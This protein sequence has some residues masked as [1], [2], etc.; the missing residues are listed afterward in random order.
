MRRFLNEVLLALVIAVVGGVGTAVLAIEQSRQS[1]AIAIGPWTARPG[2][3]GP[4]DNPYARALAATRSELPLDAAEGLVF[5]AGSDSAGDPLS[6]RCDYAV[7]G[8]APPARLWSLTVYDAETGLMD[9]PSGRTGFHSEE[10]IRDGDGRFAISLSTTVKPGN[11]LPVR[12]GS[13]PLL[14]FR[15]YDTTVG[16][17]LGGDAAAMPA[18]T[19]ERCR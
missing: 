4:Q 14:V 9:V 7:A 18:I 3:A 5:I 17:A 8:R 19:R 1:G 11:W 10:V 16:T 15:L 2:T 6:A 12:A 13:D